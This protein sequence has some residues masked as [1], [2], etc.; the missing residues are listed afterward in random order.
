MKQENVQSR[1]EKNMNRAKARDKQFM[2]FFKCD[3]ND[4]E[5]AFD[6]PP[7]RCTCFLDTFFYASLLNIVL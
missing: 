4:D 5:V 2:Y 3:T 6:V 7:L 1:K